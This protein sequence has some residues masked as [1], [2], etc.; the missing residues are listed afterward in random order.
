[1]RPLIIWLSSQ[2]H[3]NRR[4]RKREMINYGNKSRRG[5]CDVQVGQNSR[6]ARRQPVFRG[7]VTRG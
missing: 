6:G 3:D 2:S 7:T 5:V 4:E 1:M